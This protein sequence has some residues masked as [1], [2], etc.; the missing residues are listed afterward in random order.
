[1]PTITGTDDNDNGVAKPKL[2][3]SDSGD[4]IRGKKKNDFLL[5]KK[6]KDTLYGGPGNDDLDGGLGDDVLYGED[7]VGAVNP[8]DDCIDEKCD[9]PSNRRLRVMESPVM[10]TNLV[11]PNRSNRAVAFVNNDTMRGGAGND[12]LNGE[13]GNDRLDGGEDNDRLEGGSGNDFLLGG[14]GNDRLVGVDRRSKTPGRNE[15]DTL[16]GG[17]G[18]DLFVL[19]VPNV[20]FYDDF[21]P[22]N[23][24]DR[25]RAVIVDFRQEID[26]VQLEGSPQQY[27]VR[28]SS[29]QGIGSES[30][31]TRLFL[32]R[33]NQTAE[34]IAIFQDTVIRQA[35]L[36]RSS[37]KFV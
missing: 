6:G 11:T 5:G 9:K 4:T 18:N 10:N 20:V 7:S 1:M 25:D 23:S 28:S 24:G 27:A 33:P 31:D 29:A 30:P 19:G 12:F 8:K 36:S 16:V 37:F 26:T 15:S 2:V 21:D 34:L 22:K 35:D 14:R 32:I 13:S 3:G 17:A